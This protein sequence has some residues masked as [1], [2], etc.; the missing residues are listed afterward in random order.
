MRSFS[1][2]FSTLDPCWST[3]TTSSCRC[4]CNPSTRRTS[5]LS[6]WF[7]FVLEPSLLLSQMFENRNKNFRVVV[8]WENLNQSE[9][10]FSQF[11][12]RR[13]GEWVHW[14]LDYCLS[15][16]YAILSGRSMSWRFEIK[17][18]ISLLNVNPSTGVCGS[19]A[20]SNVIVKRLSSKIKVLKFQFR[21]LSIFTSSLVAMLFAHKK[22]GNLSLSRDVKTKSN[23]TTA[24]RRMM[25]F[26][27]R[28]AK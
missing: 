18:E 13:C 20:I 16:Q 23:S 25:E 21:S 28:V 14:I 27:T 17:I 12:V 4:L 15:Y 11:R 3:T 2:A 9:T 6:R 8:Q 10:C 24:S 22:N 1:L 19:L 7:L 5:A 26:L